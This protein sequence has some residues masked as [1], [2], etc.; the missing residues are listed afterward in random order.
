[1]RSVCRDASLRDALRLASARRAARYPLAAMAE[2][3]RATYAGICERAP[4]LQWASDFDPAEAR[5]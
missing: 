5:A 4:S 1:L 3:Y 2:A